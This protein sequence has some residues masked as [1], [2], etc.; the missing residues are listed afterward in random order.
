M[1]DT[2]LVLQLP[3]MLFFQS[4]RYSVGNA[5]SIAVTYFGDA[6][7]IN[8]LLLINCMHISEERIP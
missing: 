3:V 1:M 7:I 8:L 2:F 6:P 4:L 5:L